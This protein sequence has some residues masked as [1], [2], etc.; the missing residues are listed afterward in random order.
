NVGAALAG[1]IS[2]DGAA[3]TVQGA[4]SDIDGGPWWGTAPDAFHFV[5][6]P[7]AGD[8]TIITRITGSQGGRVGVMIRDSLDPLSANA[9]MGLAGG[10]S[11]FIYRPSFN[12]S[13][14]STGGPGVSTPYWFKLVR[15]G[16]VFTA[17]SSPDGTTWTQLGSPA[18]ITMGFTVLAGL[19]V[20]SQNPGA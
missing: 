6:Q 16:N 1:S 5:Y 8:G 12:A 18:T 4:G 20:C 19:A 3:F 2:Y 11:Q 10:S 7:M 15:Q 13:S 9:L 14:N 17:F